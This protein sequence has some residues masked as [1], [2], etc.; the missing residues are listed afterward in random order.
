MCWGNG[1]ATFMI[2]GER[3]TRDCRFCAVKKGPAE[4][5]AP[6]E[7]LRLAEA[8]K[9]LG[10]RYVVVTSVTRDDLPDGGAGHFART[11]SVIRAGCP[12]V[13]IEL[14]I[15]DFGGNG[16]SLGTVVRSAPDVLGHNI[17]TVARLYA[18]VRPRADYTRSLD[19][20]RDAKH[21]SPAIAVKSGIMVGMG[22]SRAELSV[23]FQ[24]LA[25]AGCDILTIG[26]YL[27]PRQD[28]FYVPV[29]RFVEPEEFSLLKEEARAC[30]IKTVQ[31]GPLVRSSF[32]AEE[33]FY[34]H[35]GRGAADSAFP[36]R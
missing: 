29:A 1:T 26:Q 34:H 30:G 20:L 21:A 16:V 23:A 13:R 36:G 7:P 22:E 33:S 31:S 27:A 8:V 12:G 28:H 4:A 11:V 3:C 2:L 25:R 19:I 24:D 9:H 10:L 18:S 5:V 32:L 6:E 14:L 15:P 17:E 35:C